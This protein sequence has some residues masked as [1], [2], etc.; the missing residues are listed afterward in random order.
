M[1]CSLLSPTFGPRWCWSL[2]WAAPRMSPPKDRLPLK[3]FNLLCKWMFIMHTWWGPFCSP[4]CEPN[5]GRFLELY[6]EYH[7]NINHDLLK[8]WTMV[9][10]VTQN[11]HF[12]PFTTNSLSLEH[13]VQYCFLSR[14]GVECA[15]ADLVAGAPCCRAVTRDLHNLSFSVRRKKR[16]VLSDN[17]HTTEKTECT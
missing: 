8:F 16:N 3:K 2:P 14:V 7:T 1:K 11:R 4:Y 10:V 13:I 15:L 6:P 17:L 5:T 9:N 12:Q